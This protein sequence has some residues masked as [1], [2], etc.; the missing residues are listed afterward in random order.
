MS[1]D[2]NVA[3]GELVRSFPKA[4]EVFDRFAIDYCCGGKSSF[5]DACARAGARFEE[6]CA[7]LNAELDAEPS[8]LHHDGDDG[9]DE[10]HATIPELVSHILD[11]H[12]VFTRRA[13]AEIAPLMAN[14]ICAH[15]RNHAVLE[16]VA[17]LYEALRLELEPHLLKEEN[18]VFPQM[19]ELARRAAA[20]DRGDATL[21]NA[22]GHPLRVMQLEHTLVGDLLCQM[23]AATEGY[24]TPADACQT[25]VK[26]YRWLAEFDRDL[27]RHFHLESN[28]L[29]PLAD[30]LKQQFE[31]VATGVG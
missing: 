28:V 2:Q 19:L 13:L 11:H 16:R 12:H 10:S 27:T 20:G 5:G 9:F 17:A 29:F 24:K 3:I 8:H 1:I 22:V 21:M 7:A 25:W 18:L 23:R 15:K 26:L 6:V 31:P 4:A 14:V 30:A